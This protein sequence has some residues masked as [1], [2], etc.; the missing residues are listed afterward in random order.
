V[1][2]NL[3]TLAAK[4]RGLFGGREPAHCIT[5]RSFGWATW[6]LDRMAGDPAPLTAVNVKNGEVVRQDRVFPKANFVYADEK[7][8]VLDEDGQE[9]GLRNKRK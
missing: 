1:I 3:R 4:L 9:E 7:L 8:I 5:A 2:H 6:S